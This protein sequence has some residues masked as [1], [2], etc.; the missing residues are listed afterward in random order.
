MKKLTVLLFT[1][2]IVMSGCS[3]TTNENATP[4]PSSSVVESQENVSIET[5]SEENYARIGEFDKNYALPTSGGFSIYS[6]KYCPEYD[7]K[8]EVLKNVIAVEAYGDYNMLKTFLIDDA[9]A[10]IFDEHGNEFDSLNS[11]VYDD[12]ENDRVYM[13]FYSD[14]D[15]SNYEYFLLGGLNADK[16]DGKTGLIFNIN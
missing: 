15:L 3:T 12:T 5:L 9:Y 13:L 1:L 7:V 8:K 16:N 10:V 2:A 6:V 4:D 14:E 11:G